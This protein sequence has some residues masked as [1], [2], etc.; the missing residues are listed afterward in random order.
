M[1]K[2]VLHKNMEGWRKTTEIIRSHGSSNYEQYL[3]SSGMRHYSAWQK[4]TN[5]S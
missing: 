4:F 3:P 5:I 2:R 1:I